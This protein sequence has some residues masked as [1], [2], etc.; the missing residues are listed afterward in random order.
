MINLQSL[1][2]TV[3]TPLREV[4]AVIDRGAAQ[5]ALVT[6]PQHRLLATVTDGD[7]R[8]GLLRGLSLDA[9]VEDVMQ[10]RFRSLPVTASESDAL[11]LMR[12]NSLHQVPV[13]DEQGR[14][15]RLYLLEELLRPQGRPNTVVLMAGGKGERLRPL[16]ADC[17]KPMLPVGGKPLLEVI[18]QQCADAGFTRFFLSVNYLKQQ[19]IDY[20]EDGSQW[21]VS[22]QYLEEG[23]PMGTGG[24]LSLL[25]EIP[26]HPLLIMNG[27]VLTRVDLGQ[28]INFHYEHAAE[29]TMCVREYMTQIPYGVVQMDGT[30][31]VGLQEKPTLS[32]FVNAGIY[33]LNPSVLR[34]LQPDLA[35]DLPVLL[36]R[37]REAGGKIA[38]FPIHEYWLDIGHPATLHRANREWQ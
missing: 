14:V 37:A 20:F 8:R 28:L 17:P 3:E 36:D 27:D 2:A 12:R 7:I 30:S 4:I 5:L 16:T 19:I 24:A 38:A 25:P 34:M 29:A 10:R 31:V 13:L 23:A 26:E 11:E 9:P 35:C 32:Y 33:V 1:Y 22:V 18:L 21:G 15:A 6:D